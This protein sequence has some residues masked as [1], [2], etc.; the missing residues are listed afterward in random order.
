MDSQR[1]RRHTTGQQLG[2]AP[3]KRAITRGS[4]GIPQLAHARGKERQTKRNHDNAREPHDGVQRVHDLGIDLF[5]VLGL[6]V[7]LCHVVIG[8]DMDHAGAQ[9]AR[10]DKAAAHELGA[11]LFLNEVALARQQALV[12]ECLARHYHGVGGNLVTAPQ[13]NDIVEHDLVQ[14]MSSTSHRRAPRWPS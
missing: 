9:Q 10:V 6:V 3:G 11:R 13:A 12:D 5:D 4:R 1:R 7:D 8:A 2:E 14:V